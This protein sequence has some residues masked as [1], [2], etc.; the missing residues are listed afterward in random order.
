MVLKRLADAQAHGDR[1]WGVIRGSAVNHDGASAGLT[2]P[3][4]AAQATVIAEALLRSGVEPSDVDYLEAHGTGTELGDP[5]EVNAAM[6]VLGRGRRVER[7]LLIGSVKTNIGHL[8]AAAGVAG[9]IKV[10][11]AINH[12][13]I[14]PHLNFRDPSPH[15]NWNRLPVRVTAEAESWPS[16]PDRPRLAGV[17]SFS[18]SGTNAHV[19][20]EECISGTDFSESPGKHLEFGQPSAVRSGRVGDGQSLAEDQLSARGTRILALSAKSAQAMRELASRYRAWLEARSVVF[21]NDESGPASS[22][23]DV[24]WT[25]SIGRS[26]FDH[27]CGLVFGSYSELMGGLEELVRFDQVPVAQKAE[28][29]AFVFTGQGSQWGGMG[30]HLY[31][32]E[33]VVRSV[34]DRCEQVLQE[35]R[36]ASLMDVMFDRPGKAGDLTTPRGLSRLCTHLRAHLPSY[37]AVWGCCRRRCWGTAWGNW[38]PHGRPESSVW[39][40][41]CASLQPAAN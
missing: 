2:V 9:V 36:G 30:R 22:L 41:G 4:E 6:S 7:P 12:R 17:S 23:A 37:G 13:A 28:R 10:I 32:T 20:L 15:V 14:P 27:R 3:S 26:H 18:L 29:I 34:L 24:A 39:R 38:R 35:I 1:I 33:P 40:T 25:A 16:S 21:A 5:I 11:L 19:I 8:E 31:E